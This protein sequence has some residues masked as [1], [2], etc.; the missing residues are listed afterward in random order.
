[1]RHPADTGFA[2]LEQR[3]AQWNAELVAID[4]RGPFDRGVSTRFAELCDRVKPDIWHGH[5]YKS[6][7]IGLWLKKRFGFAQVA[8][9]H[10]WVKHTWKT[11]L[12][13]AIDRYCLKRM[14]AVIGV[15]E[16][17]AERCRKFG[18]PAERVHFIPNAIDTEEYKRRRPPAEAKQDFGLPSDCISLCA[19]GRLSEEKGFH[20]LIPAVKRLVDAGHNLHLLIA[21]EGDQHERLTRLTSELGLADHVRLLGLVADP[22]PLYEASDGFV[23]SSLREG[24]PNVVLEAMALECPLVATRINGVPGLVTSGENGLVIEPG[25]IDELIGGLTQLVSDAGLRSRLASAARETIVSRYSFAERMR[26]VERIYERVLAE[27]AARN[28]S[29]LAKSHTRR[30]D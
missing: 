13:H 6:N 28:P 1:M 11:P 5:D 25:S 8:T 27:R 22:R 26:K 23:L 16:D 19:V 3:A 15:S 30:R 10:G 14:D 9:A 18:T 4:D 24:L 2:L 21:G 20:L 17:L 29:I 12:Y 7:L